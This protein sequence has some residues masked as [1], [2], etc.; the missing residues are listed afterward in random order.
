MSASINLD[1]LDP[2]TR[3][4]YE[5]EIERARIIYGTYKDMTL[6]DIVQQCMQ[7]SEDWFPDQAKSVPFLALA[8]C[9]EAGEFANMV[10]KMVRSGRT[11]SDLSG[12]ER[13]AIRLEAIDIFIYLCNIF[14]ILGMDPVQTYGYKREIN[15]KKYTGG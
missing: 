15:I 3:A 8:L 10:K 12:E 9:G 2:E 11:D 6:N 4:R 13:L 5:A 7:D 1:E 14:G